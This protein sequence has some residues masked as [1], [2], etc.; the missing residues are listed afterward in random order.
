MSTR[1][2]ASDQL[3]PA[4]RTFR[5]GIFRRGIGWVNDGL[6]WRS[7]LLLSLLGFS[8]ALP[9]WQARR[10]ERSLVC[11]TASLLSLIMCNG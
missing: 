4:V 8:N 7:G 3:A 2:R 6:C 5:R 10:L 11:R 9:R 1:D